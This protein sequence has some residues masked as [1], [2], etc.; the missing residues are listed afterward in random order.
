MYGPARS[1]FLN[2]TERL[3]FFIKPQFQELSRSSS[4]S[5]PNKWRN[6]CPLFFGFPSSW[7]SCWRLPFRSDFFEWPRFDVPLRPN[8]LQVAANSYNAEALYLSAQQRFEDQLF[9][10]FWP[11]D[12]QM[13]HVQNWPSSFGVSNL[14]PHLLPAA[15]KSVRPEKDAE[16]RWI[17]LW[18]QYVATISTK[19]DNSLQSLAMKQSTAWRLRETPP[20]IP[21]S[22]SQVNVR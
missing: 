18:G 3:R 1:S 21:F 15:L 14:D 7:S 4:D 17:I 6:S 22:E 2:I 12:L 8:E 9:F 16:D 11:W 19:Y 10:F 20:R 13:A 5:I